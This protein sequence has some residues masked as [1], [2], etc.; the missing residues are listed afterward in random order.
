MERRGPVDLRTFLAVG[1]FVLL[2]IVVLS[3]VLGTLTHLCGA[4]TTVAIVSGVALFTV[5][6][7]VS[8]ALFTGMFGEKTAERILGWILKKIP[9]LRWGGNSQ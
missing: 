2:A 4:G 6:L 8:V 3:G 5:L 9:T 7:I 1:G